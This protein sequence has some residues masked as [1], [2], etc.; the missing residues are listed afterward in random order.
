MADDKKVSDSVA[1]PESKETKQDAMQTDAVE[2][3]TQSEATDTQQPVDKAQEH[4]KHVLLLV[5]GVV[6][7]VFIVVMAFAAG[8]NSAQHDMSHVTVRSFG[9]D[10]QVSPNGVQYCTYGNG[11]AMPM[12]GEFGTDTG[13]SQTSTTR[14][15][16]VVTAV[17]GDTITVSGNGTTTKVTVSSNTSY[18]GSSEPAKVNDSILAFGAK[19]ASGT[20]V[21][22][23]VRLTRQ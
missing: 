11:G 1:A 18:T 23:Q 13:G 20:L 21:A 22:S 10:M 4:H 12:G 16:G 3:P 9:G 2:T 15:T 17:D 8:R 19:D 7:M 5:L 6:L 14:V